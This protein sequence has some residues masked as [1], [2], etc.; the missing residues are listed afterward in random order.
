MARK[1]DI[2][3]RGPQKSQK[4]SHSSIKTIRRQYLNLQKKVVDGKQKNVCTKCIRTMKK[5]SL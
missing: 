5:N 1:C 3:G 2:C 4:R